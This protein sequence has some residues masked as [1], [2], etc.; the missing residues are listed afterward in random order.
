MAVDRPSALVV[1]WGPAVGSAVDAGRPRDCPCAS[2]R[3]RRG[4]A[5]HEFRTRLHPGARFAVGGR[6]QNLQREGAHSHVAA[7]SFVSRNSAR[8][9]AAALDRQ[10]PAGLARALEHSWAFRGQTARGEGL[11]GPT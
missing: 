10:N 9:G 1:S 8:V 11:E 3:H 4:P 2:V 6:V 7:L 5:S